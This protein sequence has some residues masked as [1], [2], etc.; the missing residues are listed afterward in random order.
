MAKTVKLKIFRFDPD[1]GKGPTFDDF[2]VPYSEGMTILDC[3]FHIQGHMDPSLAFRV[4]C[5]AGVCGSC[6]MHIGGRYRLACET[7]ASIALSS[8]T[9]IRPLAHL[10]VLRDLV[11]DM[12]PFWAQY[13]RIMPYLMPGTTPP[14]KEFLQSPADRDRLENVVDCILCSS[15]HASCPMTASDESYIG[16]AALLKAN[17]FVADTRDHNLEQ[18]LEMVSDGHG[19]WRC[20][21]VFNCSLACPKQLDPAASIANLKRMSTKHFLCKPEPK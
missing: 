2:D 5:R 10:Q 9:A 20:H 14:G 12:K 15:C 1:N 4:S 17:R 8:R 19:V 18:R 11:V 13:K 21:T 3:L 6:A 7:Q 16:P